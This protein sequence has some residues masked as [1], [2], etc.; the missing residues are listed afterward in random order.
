MS[1]SVRPH[2]WQPTRLP[3]PWDSPG[4]NTGVGIEPAGFDIIILEGLVPTL[5]SSGGKD[6]EQGENGH[7]T[8]ECFTFFQL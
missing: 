8:S 4:N 2:R 3:C 5:Q 7:G 6:A 1:D